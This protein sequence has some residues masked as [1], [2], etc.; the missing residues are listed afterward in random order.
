MESKT[1]PQKTRRHISHHTIILK[2]TSGK[3]LS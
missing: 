2:I 1:D 3:V